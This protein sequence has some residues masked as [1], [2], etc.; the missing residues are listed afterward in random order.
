MIILGIDPGTL[1]TGYGIIERTRS[2]LK[3]IDV[4]IIKNS[5]ELSM[6]LRLKKIYS[7]LCAIIEKWAPDE[8]AIETAFYSKNA[9][10]ALK[11]G[12]ARGV[13]ILAGVNYE[14]P[15]S[16]YSPR[17]VKKAVFGNGAAS[18]EQIQFMIMNELKLKTKPRYLDST[19]ALAVAVCHSRRITVPHRSF[20]NWKTFIEANP[21]RVIANSKVKSIK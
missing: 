4:G 8:F 6:P 13:A 7:S 1:I 20:K 9:Q 18:K 19:D 21:E 10:S 2:S 15:V 14:I 11:I 17:E 3:L 5:S 12:Q 16:E